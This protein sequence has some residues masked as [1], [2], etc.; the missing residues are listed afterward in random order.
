MYC[1][2]KNLLP[3]FYY[4]KPWVLL[5]CLM[6]TRESNNNI[7]QTL[8][9]WKAQ[10]ISVPKGRGTVSILLIAALLHTIGNILM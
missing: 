2:T 10:G 1:S 6:K 4:Y 7:I 9:Q 5:G 3:K 8:R